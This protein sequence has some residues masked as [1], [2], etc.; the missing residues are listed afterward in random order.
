MNLL[1]LARR[2][3]PLLVAFAIAMVASLAHAQPEGSEAYYKK[4]VEPVEKKLANY[5]ELKRV[6]IKLDSAS[7][8]P[9]KDWVQKN[10]STLKALEV[11]SEYA[12]QLRDYNAVAP[13]F[14]KAKLAFEDDGSKTPATSLY[15]RNSKAINQLSGEGYHK[16]HLEEFLALLKEKKKI[17]LDLKP[18]LTQPKPYVLLFE[19]F[20]KDYPEIEYF[21]QSGKAAT[22]GSLECADQK[23]GLLA[24]FG[25]AGDEP[26][27]C[28]TPGDVAPGLGSF[29]SQVSSALKTACTETKEDIAKRE[30][31]A[32]AIM[33]KMEMPSTNAYAKSLPWRPGFRECGLSET[34]IK[35]LF[36]YTGIFYKDIN[37]ALR[38][39]KSESM[40]PLID[41][42]NSALAKLKPHKGNV[43]RGTTSLGSDDAEMV[44]GKIK[45]FKAFTSASD[46]GTVFAGLYQ[47]EIKSCNG[48]YIAPL[49][50]SP[51]EEEVLFKPETDF[52]IIERK[53]EDG[54]IRIKLEEVCEK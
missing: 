6:H 54:E 10:G 42:V 21:I 7:A 52:K 39:G 33:A 19:E 1:K 41:T 47:F 40:K 38:E 48:R 3:S 44:P 51:N 18:D 22:K 20:R 14:G 36:M 49:S 4:I 25:L 15:L 5:P 31:A 27:R 16:R 34:E 13:I 29:F 11:E 30:E 24:F 50:G 17:S 35:A 23:S 45:R 32:K 9:Y 12:Q 28:E 26:K 8:T 46:E 53:K 37:S 43:R 2:L